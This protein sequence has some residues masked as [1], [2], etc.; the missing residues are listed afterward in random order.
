MGVSIPDPAPIQPS[1]VEIVRMEFAF[2][3]LKMEQKYLRLQEVA[4][5]AENNTRIYKHKAQRMTK[6]YT[7]TKSETENLYIANKKLWGQV[8]DTKIRRFFGTHRRYGEVS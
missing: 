2:E 6:D 4:N 3:R 1:K 8:K 7:K 5:K